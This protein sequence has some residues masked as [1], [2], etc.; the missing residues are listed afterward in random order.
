MT[1][2]TAILFPGQGSQEAGMG[3]D[4]AES[5][6]D[7][8]A[9]WKK[10]ETIS[11]LPLR[12]IYWESGDPALMADTRNLQPALTVV[13]LSLW[14][15]LAPHVRPRAGAGHSLG[16]YSAYAASGALSAD[17]VLE[18]VSLRG[19]LMADADPAGRGGMAAL[20]KLSR[21]DAEAVAREAAESAGELLIVANYNTPAQFVLSGAKKALEAALPLAKARKGRAMPLSVS[22]AFHTPLMEKAA[23]EMAGALRKAVWNRPR[24]PL[25]SNVTGGAVTDGESLRDLACRQMTSPVLWID[26]I[27]AQWADGVRTWLEVGPKGVLTRMVKPI[28][29]PLGGTEAAEALSI[30]SREAVRELA[31]RLA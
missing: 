2:V 25:Y 19:A 14:L 17:T 31:Q 26:T 16:E 22:S 29:D 23:S 11:G 3:R 1:S 7:S 18:L 27:A 8:M 24:F 21:E 20:L 5:N 28:L 30:D 13:N 12:S 10:A 6:N 9:L 15:E 4:L